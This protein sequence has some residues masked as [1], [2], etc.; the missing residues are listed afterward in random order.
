VAQYMDQWR[1][2]VNVVINLWVPQN[3]G[4]FLSGCTSNGLSDS[5]QLHRVMRMIY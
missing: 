5:A 3:A 1:A 4:K 2:F